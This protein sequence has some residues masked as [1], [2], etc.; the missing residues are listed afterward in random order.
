[1]TVTEYKNTMEG[2][3]AYKLHLRIIKRKKNVKR[4]F[5]G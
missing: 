2:N 4:K 3:L 1:M 5:I